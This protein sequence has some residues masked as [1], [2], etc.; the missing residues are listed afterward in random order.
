M[1]YKRENGMNA[2]DMTF[3]IEIECYL[4]ESAFTSGAV[5]A[6]G[7]HS[8]V[9]VPGLPA[10][11]NAQRDGSLSSYG[12]GRRGVE[13][14]SPVLKGADGVRQI[15]EVCAWLASVGATVRAE[16]G[17]HVHVGFDGS[18]ELGLKNLVHL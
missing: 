7:Y 10:G 4:P 15:K 18:N 17:F 1:S 14:V 12:R 9:Q 11:W 5:V 2:S 3:G 16:C 8:G 6:G 13:I